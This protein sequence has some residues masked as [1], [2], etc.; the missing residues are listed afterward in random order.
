MS[1]PTFASHESRKA[2]AFFEIYEIH[3]LLYLSRFDTSNF[4]I[5][6]PELD[7]PGFDQVTPDTYYAQ[8]VFYSILW[9]L[10]EFDGLVFD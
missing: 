9:Y 1:K 8:G 2:S 10:T 5:R 7:A 6:C 3:V 4:Q